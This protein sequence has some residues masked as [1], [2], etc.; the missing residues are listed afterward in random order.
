MGY[1]KLFIILVIPS[2]IISYI[3]QKKTGIR[4]LSEKFGNLDFIS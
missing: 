2:F 3:S 1:E 4:I